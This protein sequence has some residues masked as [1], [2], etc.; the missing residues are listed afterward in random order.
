MRVPELVANLHWGKA[1]WRTLFMCAT[2]SIYA[3]RT[4]IGPR[5]EP[6]MR[7]NAPAGPAKSA[8]SAAPTAP[9]RASTKSGLALD[10]SRCA[11]IIQDM[12]NDVVTEGGAFA[13]SGAPQHAREQNVV[14]NIRRL[15]EV[16]RARGTMVIHV[17]FI[18]EPGAPGFTLNAPLFEGVVDSNAMVRGT[19]GAAPVAGLNHSQATTSSK[20]CG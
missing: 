3:L 7:P 5:V 6:F 2:H 12:Q 17:W 13:A 1:D 11:L 9:E 4:K 8:T 20:R 14:E 10:P 16:C 15:A 19:W 18:V